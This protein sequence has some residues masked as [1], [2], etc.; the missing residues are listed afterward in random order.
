MDLDN[1]INKLDLIDIYRT[2]NKS[3]MNTLLKGTCNMYPTGHILGHKTSLNTSERIQGLQSIFSERN[4]IKLEISN[5]KL[6]GVMHMFIILIVVMVSQAYPHTK[7]Y[8]TVHFTFVQ[9]IVC[10]VHRTKLFQKN[11]TS[12][13]CKSNDPFLL[14][15]S[16]FKDSGS[17]E[18]KT[19]RSRVPRLHPLLS[20]TF[21]TH[22]ALTH[23][24]SNPCI[25]FVHA[26]PL[27]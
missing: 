4:G 14:L 22:C 21:Y 12:L 24:A 5:R 13:K 11:M 2:L 1:T 23:P 16:L 8:Q 18:V 17:C 15:K 19:G 9:L 10:H 25:A 3:R 20:P 26:I 7:T 6:L 27:C